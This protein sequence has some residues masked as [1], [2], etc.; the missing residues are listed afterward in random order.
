MR[1]I[2]SYKWA[3]VPFE[4]AVDGRIM[5]LVFWKEKFDKYRLFEIYL[6][7]YVHQNLVTFHENSILQFERSKKELDS[8][9]SFH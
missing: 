7:S 8:R 3:H 9:H 2:F 1:S 4:T 5:F 6:F